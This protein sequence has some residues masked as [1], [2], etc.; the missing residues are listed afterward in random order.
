MHDMSC[1]HV[2]RDGEFICTAPKVAKVHPA[3]NLLGDEAHQAEFKKQVTYRKAQEKDAAGYVK[4]VLDSALEDQ[5]QRMK[6]LEVKKDEKSESAQ[7]KPLTQAK[8]TS[9]EAAKTKAMEARAAAP[10]YTPP[11]ENP[12][13]LTELEKYEYLFELFYR[14]GI[15][16]REP[17][18]EWMEY[19]ENT[20]EYDNIRARC[21][22]R[23]RFF[24]QK[25]ASN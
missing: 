9:I 10:A 21:E 4:G 23:K 25:Q 1:I 17:D 6:E 15:S 2:Y 3:A 5:Q 11:E 13:I 18:Q 19:F 24:V 22:Q 12:E 8:I 7:P 20:D 16:L 14:D